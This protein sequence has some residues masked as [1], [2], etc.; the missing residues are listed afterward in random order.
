MSARLP[1]QLISIPM[2]VD[3][4]SRQ[5]MGGSSQCAHH[6]VLH[7]DRREYM[8]WICLNCD[9][10]CKY[11]KWANPEVFAERERSR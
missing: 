5:T 10:L 6:Y 9:R 8:E 7:A 1:K 4:R 11:D 3:P 2:E